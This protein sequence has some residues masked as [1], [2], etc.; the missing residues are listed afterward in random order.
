[1]A[2]P[3]FTM[4]SDATLSGLY[5]V[6]EAEEIDYEL[7][8]ADGEST[9][10]RPDS[11]ALLRSLDQPERL[12]GTNLA[13]FGIDELSYARPE[14]WLRLEARLRDPKATKLCGFGVW[15]PQGH[16]LDL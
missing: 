3:T 15:T 4:L 1:M 13:W 14:A 6:L 5:Q 10:V 8:K 11:T 9:L 2:A 12:R 16:A 7:R